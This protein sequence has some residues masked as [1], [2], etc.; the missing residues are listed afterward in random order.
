MFKFQIHINTSR[1]CLIFQRTTIQIQYRQEIEACTKEI[2]VKLTVKSRL[3]NTKQ[4]MSHNPCAAE[5][6]LVFGFS[7][8]SEGSTP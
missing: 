8:S 2:A 6:Q 4:L 5:T 7:A 1:K 3:N